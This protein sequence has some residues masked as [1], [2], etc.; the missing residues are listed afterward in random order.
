MQNTFP[1]SALVRGSLSLLALATALSFSSP[2]FAQDAISHPGSNNSADSSGS[3]VSGSSSSPS[4]ESGSSTT[5]TTQQNIIVRGEEVPSSYG[6]PPAQ[7][8]SRFSNLVNA[9]VLPPF[10]VYA[11]AIYEG[12]ALR[13]NRPDHS[14]TTE[15]E[16]GLP[17][18]F[19]VAFENA[20]ET[21]RGTTQERSFS[22]EARYALADWDKIP[23]NPTLFFEYKFGIG[24]ILHDEG[25]PAPAGPG[26][27]Q[28]F[29]N[30]HNPLPDAV[31]VRLLLAET[32]GEV[33]WALNGFF[34]QE[35]SGDRGREYGFAQAAMVP[36]ILPKE[37]L[38]VGVEMQFMTFTDKGIR[39]DPSY[40]FIIGPTIAWKPSKNTRF[41]VSPLFGTTDD[42]P[43]A[44]VFAIFSYVFGGSE[45]T[46][47]EAPASTR[48]R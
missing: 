20:V 36:V 6:A 34:E 17:Y 28:A 29:L 31:E 43:R 13:F 18:R 32:F 16:L 48:N 14:Y 45:G 23:L 3:S 5:N 22:L 10:A 38:K 19:G 24:D 33:E 15:V 40:R 30:E 21:F 27:A 11:A 7:S 25:P 26:E 1:V 35:T 42:S 44:S 12:D 47:A 4:S 46:E 8:R 2:G 9:Y 37:R 41:D 39:N